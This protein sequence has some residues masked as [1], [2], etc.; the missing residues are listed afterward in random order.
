MW[1]EEFV[2][3][4]VDDLVG[5]NEGRFVAIDN[6]SGRG[7]AVSKLVPCLDGALGQMLCI[8]VAAIESNAI[9]PAIQVHVRVV[10]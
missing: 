9:H 1:A 4:F 7:Q 3:L 8:R 2:Q 6:Q 5:D 10:L